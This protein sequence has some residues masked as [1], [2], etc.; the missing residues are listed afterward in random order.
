MVKLGDLLGGQQKTS[1]DKK[2]AAFVTANKLSLNY[3]Q[4]TSLR[5]T[6]A[7]NPA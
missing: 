6:P 2:R 7:V 1:G 3:S 4:L 5:L